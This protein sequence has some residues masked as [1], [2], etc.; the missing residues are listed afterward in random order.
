MPH[1]CS[2]YVIGRYA[3]VGWQRATTIL[4]YDLRIHDYIWVQ[5]FDVSTENSQ[6]VLIII[7]PIWNSQFWRAIFISVAAIFHDKM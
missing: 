3:M 7:Q 6:I 2:S 4:S 5:C 1:T